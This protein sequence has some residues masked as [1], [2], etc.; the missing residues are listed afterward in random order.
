MPLLKDLGSAVLV[1]GKQMVSYKMRSRKGAFS[2]SER[3]LPAEDSG[4]FVV[5]DASPPLLRAT[6]KRRDDL[7]ERVRK[8]W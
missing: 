5:C 8:D 7:A 4:T 6:N 3:C 2:Q 1:Y